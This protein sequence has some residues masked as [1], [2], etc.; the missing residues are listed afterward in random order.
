MK[1]ILQISKLLIFF[2]LLLIFSCGKN[3]HGGKTVLAKVYDKYLYLEDIKEL[4][5]QNM[6]PNDS[7]VMV[8]NIIDLWVKKQLMLNK[9][10]LYLSDEQ[11]DVEENVE[12]YRASLLIYRYKQEFLKQKL[13]TVVTD[14]QVEKYY[15]ENQESFMSNGESVIALLVKLPKNSNKINEFRNLF[16]SKSE[17]SKENLLSFCKVNSLAFNNFSDD[18]VYFSEISNLLPIKIS[19]PDDILKTTNI[20][21]TEDN[22]FQYFVK[23]YKY[24]LKGEVSPLVFVEEQIKSVILNKRKIEII[25]ELES[26]IFQNALDNANVEIISKS[27]ESN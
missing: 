23:I 14:A 2:S 16:F 7:A 27:K 5:N 9:A 10:D 13:D 8:R 17:K 12:D 11:K 22:E 26:T 18:W 15:K 24:R 6:T 1:N 3:E 4:E 21:Q 25:E 19:K 20:I